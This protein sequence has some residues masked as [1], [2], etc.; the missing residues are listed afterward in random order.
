MNKSWF[1]KIIYLSPVPE[2]SFTQRP[3]QFADWFQAEFDSEVLWIEP[4]PARLPNYR[5]IINF[6]RGRQ[7][8]KSEERPLGVNSIRPYSLPV[9]PLPGAGKLQHW[10]WRSLIRKIKNFVGAERSLLVI[11]K[12]CEL[13][14]QLLDALPNC[15]SVYDA[16]DDFPMFYSGLSR[17]AMRRREISMAN[18]VDRILTS[19]SY[20]S[21]KFKALNRVAC[22]VPNACA[23]MDL[24][25]P[26]KL[27]PRPEPPVLGYVGTM[28]PWFDWPLVKALAQANPKSILRLVGPVFGLEP[29]AMP[30]N[31]QLLPPCRHET[32]I[33]LMLG[34]SVG[35]I[36]FKKNEIT[37]AVDPIKYYEYLALGR[38]VLTTDFGE[39]STRRA[40]HGVHFLEDDLREAVLEAGRCELPPVFIRD[41][42]EKNDWR[43]RFETFA[44]VNG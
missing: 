16:M 32:A 4:Y 3:H 35:L 7:N 2:N 1:K 25:P 38:P 24:P 42:R 13:A 30:A 36:P 8:P 5:D 12:P 22:F 39:M 40:E 19:S 9:E 34:F 14:L 27:P 31:I 18:R 43:R 6:F 41:F 44:G 10:F 17:K 11:G 33:E 29:G 37:A 21:A 23:T 15:Y 20:L 26:E 28:G